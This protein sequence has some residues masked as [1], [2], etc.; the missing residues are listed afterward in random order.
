[1]F[2]FVII[3]YTIPSDSPIM[4]NIEY[5]QVRGLI[6]IPSVKPF[7]LE[8]I[9]QQIDELLIDDI[10]LNEVD[11][12]IISSFNPLLIKNESFSTLF[13]MKGEYQYEPE[14]HC[15]FLDSRIGG[16]LTDNIRYS[17]AMRFKRGSVID[18]FG[19]EPWRDFQVYLDE[20]LIKLNINGIEFDIGR[21]NLNLSS[22]NENSLILSPG[23]EGYDGFLLYIPARYFDFHNTLSILDAST[24]RYISV[25]RIGLNLKKFFKLG[26]SES[27]LYARV[28]EPLYL[29]PFLPYY[30]SQWGIDRDDNV[31]W[32]LDASLSLFNS[33]I[34]GELLIDDYRFEIEAHPHKLAYKIGIKSLI[35]KNFLAKLK[36][37]FVDKWVYTHEIPANIYTRNN[38]PL[39]FPLG[40]DIDELSISIR[41]M[42]KYGLYP[43]FM[44]DYVR[45]G[46]GS[47]FIPYEDEPDDWQPPFPSGIV[48]RKLDIKFGLNYIFKYNSYVKANI[49][50]RHWINYDNIN[51]NDINNTTLD[52]AIWFVM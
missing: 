27:I 44:I 14:F 22:D 10:T 39:G 31:M 50:K 37:T 40:N 46:E 13:H 7:E 15:G 6:D 45:K 2:L 26:F 43:S 23:P 24:N 16:S 34:Y 18:S 33:V 42:N 35:L 51:G 48:E 32:C 30:L 20:G 52:L 49:G 17:Q 36:Y 19:P 41:F 29:N 9:V 25:H 4:D 8:W 47:I 1:M 5:L 12:K 38:Y 3:S 21:R 11:R 28:L